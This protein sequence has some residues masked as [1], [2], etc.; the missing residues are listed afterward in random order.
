MLSLRVDLGAM[1]IRDYYSPKITILQSSCITEKQ[2]TDNQNSME[3]CT[4]EQMLIQ[5][6]QINAEL[7]KKIMSE[8][9]TI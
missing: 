5:E 6:D 4:L 1:A 3:F 2:S 8:K 7:I 9:K